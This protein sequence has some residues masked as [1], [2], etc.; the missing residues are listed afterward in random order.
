MK[1]FMVART[2]IQDQT[3]V[4]FGAGAAAI[5][6]AGYLKSAVV[7]AGLSPAEAASRFFIVNRKGLLNDRRTELLPEQRP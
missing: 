4:M 7:S 2:K 5:G 1:T 3:I 6:V